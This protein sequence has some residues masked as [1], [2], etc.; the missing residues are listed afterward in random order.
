MQDTTYSMLFRIGVF[1]LARNQAA[2]GVTPYL[3]D[4]PKRDT[5]YSSKDYKLMLTEQLPRGGVVIMFSCFQGGPKPVCGLRRDSI[6]DSLAALVDTLP[7]RVRHANP[8]GFG[9]AKWGAF[10]G[11]DV[12]ARSA[13]DADVVAIRDLLRS[14]VFETRPVTSTGQAA[15]LAYRALPPEARMGAD[16]AKTGFD[17]AV[18]R[19]DRTF[20]VRFRPC[21]P[22]EEPGDWVWA[23]RVHENGSVEIADR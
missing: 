9:F 6:G 2:A 5:E 21:V 14:V 19:A 23:Y 4:W 22:G 15:Q 7:M 16:S 3:R 1:G 8:F 13:S 11:I 12:L 20:A 10:W 17:V 18:T